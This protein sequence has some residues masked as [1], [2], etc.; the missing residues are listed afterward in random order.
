MIPATAVLP[1][2]GHIPLDQHGYPVAADGLYVNMGPTARPLQTRGPT[3]TCQH[4]QAQTTSA[5]GG[6]RSPMTVFDFPPPS[7][8]TVSHPPPPPQPHPRSVNRGRGSDR[9]GHAGR[10]PR[11]TSG[12]RIPKPAPTPAPA[13]VPFPPPQAS[14]PPHQTSGFG[15]YASPGDVFDFPPPT[16]AVPPPPPPRR[17]DVSLGSDRRPV[18]VPQVAQGQPFIFQPREEEWYLPSGGKPAVGRFSHWIM[19]LVGVCCTLAASS[20]YMIWKLMMFVRLWRSATF[21]SIFFFLLECVLYVAG[22]VYLVE[23][24]RPTIPRTKKLLP[25]SGP[26]PLVAILIT[27]CKE[28]LDVLKDTVRAALSQ[29]Y[30]ADR[31]CVCVLDDGG[32]DELKEWIELMAKQLQ[33]GL[34]YIR[35][36]KQ[37]GVP[38]HY[39]AGNL[40]SALREV[41]GE[42]I[43]IV[44]ADMV[45]SPNFLAGMLP[46][47]TSRKI[48]FVQS[49]QSFYN[50]H[51]GDPLNDSGIFF[52][53]LLLPHRDAWGSAQC[54]GTGAIFRRECLNEI[55]FFATGSVTEDFDTALQLHCRLYDSVYIQQRFQTG[56]TPWTLATFIKQHQRWC[57]GGIQILL[58]RGPLF[59][60][61]DRFGIYRRIIYFYAGAHWL[62]AFVVVAFLVMA[63]I[64]LFFDMS[65]LPT[66]ASPDDFRT[67]VK[68]LAPYLLLSRVTTQ[69]L[70]LRI[71]G[72]IFR[73]QVRIRDEQMLER[74]IE[75]ASN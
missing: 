16:P 57:M 18:A 34:W 6:Y 38:H 41:W 66:E 5:F 24:S 72:F 52:Y 1:R 20:V 70:Y 36:I 45:L 44:D 50:I 54:V 60:K 14:N 39:K 7:P 64:L 12:T 13:P 63:P 26:F 37:E 33:R 56:L 32:D 25:L 8:V 71:P 3:P 35:R 31:Y 75:R 73:Q 53:D 27:C 49:P 23:F 55:G 4:P 61:D 29:N 11:G 21:V 40:N 9:H 48:A 74:G 65:M 69:V 62:L 68:M 42:F 28:K 15:G 10:I 59:I 46:H 67:Y 47:F 43:A 19:I 22:F 30:P 51:P 2:R 17:P 58:K